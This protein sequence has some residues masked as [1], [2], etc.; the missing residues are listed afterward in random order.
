[1]KRIANILLILIIAL[2]LLLFFYWQ[3]NK[4]VIHIEAI[5]VNQLSDFFDSL[6]V[7]QI[8]DLHIKR[9][10]NRERELVSL[11]QKLDSHLIFITGDFVSNNQ[12]IDPALKVVERIAQGRKVI[13]VLGN[14]DHEFRSQKIDTEKLVQGLEK[15]GILVLLNQSIKLKRGA[16]SVFV[17][18]LDDNYLWK[19]DFFKATAD[20]PSKGERIL[21]AHS[22]DIV[23]KVKL[24]NIDLVLSGHTHGGQI[25]LPMIGAVYTNRSCNS[26]F[27]FISGLYQYQNTKLYV[28]R[29]I[30]VSFFP[31]RFL[32]RPEITLF[33]FE[34]E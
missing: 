25:R 3:S 33:K 29:G 32:C 19:D 16:D 7:V 27:K 8:S 18:G 11:I 22:P 21:L 2:E 5:K 23:T 13:A 24:V 12:G 34:K 15:T 4:I 6:K 1:M 17:I 31:V 9:L 26:V 30:G 28:N 14:N 20:L 10:G